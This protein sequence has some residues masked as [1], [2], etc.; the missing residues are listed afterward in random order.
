MTFSRVLFSFTKDDWCTPLDLFA[1]LDKEF[2]FRL[3]PCTTDDNPLQTPIYYT[4]ETDGLSKPWY[5]ATFV[6]P[7]Y[8]RIVNKWLEKAVTETKRGVTSVFLLPARVDTQWFHSYIYQK[9][10][11]ELRFIK[12]RL[13][14][15]APKH[16]DN[17]K[18]NDLSAPF[19]SL[20]A[21]FRP[22]SEID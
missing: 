3:D 14:F 22:V 2:H 6:N 1:S 15:T 21:I 17:L 13:K 7:P 10:N 19:P 8:G 16:Y 9:K 20:I 5:D 12:G 4:K 18:Y 11:V